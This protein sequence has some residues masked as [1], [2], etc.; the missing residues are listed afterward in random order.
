G[1]LEE[2]VRPHPRVVED[3][4]E[5]ATT[6]VGQQHNHDRL[7]GQFAGDPQRAGDGH[8]AGSAHEDA[9]LQGEAAGHRERLSVVDRDDLVQHLG[10]VGTGPDVLPHTLDEVG[11]AGAARVDAAL[12]VDAD[13]AHRVI[14]H[15]AQEAARARDR[16]A[17]A[18]AGDEVG[19][20]SVSVAPDLGPGRPLGADRAVRVPGLL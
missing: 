3:L 19:D 17:G 2:A 8:A 1:G 15:L 11:P 5:V 12:G 9:L 20:P 10:V 6:A 14:G 16:A 7:G 18:D 13:D 4:A